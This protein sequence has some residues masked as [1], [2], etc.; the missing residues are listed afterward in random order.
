M[1]ELTF[2]LGSLPQEQKELKRV[3]D[4]SKRLKRLKEYLDDHVEVAFPGS[5]VSTIG[6]SRMH[7]LAFHFERASPA[8]DHERGVPCDVGCC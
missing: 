6:I 5:D 1:P 3:R 2:Y 8:L 4:S 7:K